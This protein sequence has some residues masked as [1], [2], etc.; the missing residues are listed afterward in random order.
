MT[1][2]RVSH[3]ARAT[4]RAIGAFFYPDELPVESFEDDIAPILQIGRE[5]IFTSMLRTALVLGTFIYIAFI[6]SSISKSIAILLTYSALLFVT[7]CI[8]IVRGLAFNSRFAV[9]AGMLYT[10]AAT[11]MVNYGLSDDGRL[12]LVIF[13]LFVLVFKGGKA[14]IYAILLS[15]ATIM[16]IG[17]LIVN[18]IATASHSVY[19]QSVLSFE[20]AIAFAFNFLFAT[21]FSAVSIVVLLRYV[22]EAW[23]SERAS[24]LSLAQQ[25]AELQESLKREQ[26]LA[27]AL[28]VSL[29]R[30]QALG[31]LRSRVMTTVSHEFRTPLTVLKNSANLLDQ[32]SDRLSAEKKSN[33]LKRI[34]SSVATLTQ[35]MHSAE[36]IGDVSDEKLE[37]HATTQSV[38]KSMEPMLAKL[39]KGSGAPDRISAEISPTCNGR[40]LTTDPSLVLQ[41]CQELMSNALKF[42]DDE[43]EVHVSAENDT[44][45]ISIHDNGIGIPT[46]DRERVFTLLERAENAG[47]V[48]GLGAGLFVS[49]EMARLLGGDVVLDSD[50]GNRGSTFTLCLPLEP[51]SE[52]EY[53]PMLEAA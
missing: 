31:D 1:G 30:E 12:F 25:S 49:R 39:V 47:T 41:V 32:Y 36:L 38:R 20:H 10:L 7:A 40:I 9:G 51:L 17:A 46:N 48:R 11:D 29:L 16:G 5:Q 35:L 53:M 43:V 4:M 6:V 15:S 22:Q 42:S 8:G 37:L 50:G 3:F 45:T 26:Q 44:L 34:Q 23:R 33:H 2:Q 13:S 24:T 14:G 18:G 27:S 28:K 21:G 52:P 19:D